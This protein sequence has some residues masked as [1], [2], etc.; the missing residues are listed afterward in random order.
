MIFIKFICIKKKKQL[1]Q[2]ISN[3]LLIVFH[4]SVRVLLLEFFDSPNNENILPRNDLKSQMNQKIGAF[5]ISRSSVTC[6]AMQSSL[7]AWKK[8]ETIKITTNV[9]RF[10]PIVN[11]NGIFKV[12]IYLFTTL[13]YKDL[14][15]I[16]LCNIVWKS[17]KEPF[18][19]SHMFC[20]SY[21]ATN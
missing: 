6:T 5:I 8:S 3:V 20:I 13:Y 12:I 19:F 11:Y 10:L 2:T 18:N 7:C 21:S 16:F 14:L 1:I 9:D 4:V 17:C 15:G